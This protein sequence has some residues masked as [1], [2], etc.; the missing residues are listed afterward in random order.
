M[1]YYLYSRKSSESE[2][3]QVLSIEAQVRELKEYAQKNNL[4]I[5]K[6]FNESRTAKEPH[7]GPCSFCLMI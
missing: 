1:K 7:C 3:R 2:D 6:E 4:E 5:V